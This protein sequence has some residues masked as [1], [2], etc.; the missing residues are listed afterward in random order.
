MSNKIYIVFGATGEYSDHK[1]W[2]VKAFRSQE[3]AQAF[4]IQLTKEAR[5][6]LAKYNNSPSYWQHGKDFSRSEPF[7]RP[8][9]D[10]DFDCDYSGVNYYIEETTLDEAKE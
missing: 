8:P 3:K 7:E 6:M 9:N 2:P 4:V 1:E 5:V 10:P